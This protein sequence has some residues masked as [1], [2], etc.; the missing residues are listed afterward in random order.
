[1]MRFKEVGVKQ[2]SK[3]VISSPRHF[4]EILSNLLRYGIWYVVCYF[5]TWLP[6]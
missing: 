1:M 5:G 2:I 3:D 4:K 6:F